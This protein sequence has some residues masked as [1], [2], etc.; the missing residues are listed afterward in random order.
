MVSIQVARLIFESN[1]ENLKESSM[2]FELSSNFEFC[3]SS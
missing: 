1:F 3:K 2:K